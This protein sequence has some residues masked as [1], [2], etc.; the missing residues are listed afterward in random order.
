M[1]P[2]PRCVPVILPGLVASLASLAL[3]GYAIF[4]S[5]LLLD[6]FALLRESWTWPAACNHLWIPHNEHLAPLGRLSTWLMVQLG[7][8]RLTAMPTLAALHGPLAVLLGMWLF[9]LFVRRETGQPFHGLLAMV[10]FGVSTQYNQGVTWYSA[11]FTVLALDTTFL[12]LLAFQR[13]RQTGRVRHLALGVVWVALAPAWFASGILAGPLCCLYLLPGRS[14][15]GRDEATPTTSDQ[16]GRVSP[17]FMP[18]PCL[19]RFAPLLGSLLFLGL[20]VLRPDT[21]GRIVQSGHYGGQTVFEALNPVV[22]LRYTARALV[23]HLVLGTLG[24]WKAACPPAL[25]LAGLALLTICGAWWWW[26]APQRRLLL[27]GLGFVLGSD[28]FIYSVRAAWSYE[29]MTAWNRYDLLPHVGLALFVVGGLGSR[30]PD[31]LDL[32]STCLAPQQARVLY[33]LTALLL[34][35][36]L[37]RGIGFVY[38]S[39]GWESQIAALRRVERM[40]A[41]CREHRIA[42]E[43]AHMAL[44][45]LDLPY[46]DRTGQG[47]QFLR[48]SD[49]PLPWTVEDARRLLVQ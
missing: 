7:G 18:L 11:S 35:S 42:A 8:G 4:F 47:W 30:Q 12:S 26:R 32:P 21:A 5:F 27:L 20:L 41:R 15:D 31:R 9:Y 49:D 29:Q 24:V 39:G 40:D 22:G 43:T 44:G 46:D 23:D 14:W 16:S 3:N 28:L 25:V 34:V 2:L 10:I 33:L 38:N 13:W 19:V 17:R 1:A 48:G 36:Q 45:R 6:D 37:P